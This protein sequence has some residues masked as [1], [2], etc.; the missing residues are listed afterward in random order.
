MSTIAEIQPIA[1]IQLNARRGG[2]NGDAVVR[3]AASFFGAVLLAGCGAPPRAPGPPGE[4]P[5][6]L[7]NAVDG[8]CQLTW[9]DARIDNRP[10]DRVTITPPGAKPATLDRPILGPGEH[11]VSV[12]AS[13]V[14]PDKAPNDQPAVLSL[15]QPVYMKDAGGQITISLANDSSSSSG[16]KV[17]ISVEGGHVLA[18]RADG[19]EVDCRSRM[20]V[21][22]AI[23]RTETALARAQ[24][25]RDVILMT[26]ISEKLRE[27]RHLAETAT[28]PAASGAAPH[29]DVLR[30]AGLERA[31]RVHALA[32]EADRCIGEETFAGDS[33]RTETSRSGGVSAFR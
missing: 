30:D 11:T 24:E 12:S 13:A 33:M 14:C 5:I 25:R 22:R 20:P 21:D 19:G 31:A 29:D 26:C 7:E 32:K 3:A 17:S 15:S 4:T 2:G 23:C 28:P 10:L 16:L 9:A 18:P 1:S 27:M 6:L 8:P